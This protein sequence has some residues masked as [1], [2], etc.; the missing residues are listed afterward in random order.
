MKPTTIVEAIERHARERPDAVAITVPGDGGGEDLSLTFA[1]VLERSRR[2][3][4]DI[5]R[6]APE[7]KRVMVLQAPGIDFALS[8]CACFIAGV[9][10]VPTP[11][12]AARANSNSAQRFARLFSDAVPDAIVTSSGLVSRAR[13]LIETQIGM[14]PQIWVMSDGDAHPDATEPSCSAVTPHDLALIQ[15]TSGSTAAPKGVV[16]DHANLAANLAAIQAWF[17]VTPDSVVVNWLP[18]YHDMGLIGGIIEA[19]WCGYRVVLM[20]P[21]TFI[22]RPIAWLEAIDRYRADVSGGANFAYDLCTDALGHAEGPSLDLSRWRLAFSG[23]EPVRATTIDRFTEAFAP[24]GFNKAAFYPCYGLAEATLMA[25]GPA[26]GAVRPVVTHFDAEA[27]ARGL[28]VPASG[29]DGGT[30]RALVSCGTPCQGLALD[31]TDPDSGQPLPH[32]REGEVRLSGPSVMRGYWRDTATR[33]REPL[34]TGDLGFIWEGAL[35][36]TGR[37]KD[38][39]IIRGRNVAPGDVENALAQCHPALAP[40][41]AAAFPVE[42]GDGE[43]LVVAV[44]IRRDHRRNTDWPRVFAAMQGRFADQMGLTATDIVL[45][46]PGALA[47]TTSGKIRRRT[48]RQ[49]YIDGAWKPLARL[50]GALE[51]AGRAGPAK[52]RRMANADRIERMAALVDYLIWRLAQLTAQPEAFLG[53]DTPV[54]GIG[55][56]SLKQVEFL[57]LVESDLG[58]ALPMDWSASAT[59][60][61]SLADLIQSHRD[62]A[63]ATTGDEHGAD[64]AVPGSMVPLSPRQA[65]FFAGTPANPDLFVEVLYLRTP[66][67]LDVDALHRALAALAAAHDAF[68]LRFF[69]DKGGWRARVSDNGGG[70]HF[71][72]IDIADLKKSELAAVRQD[73]LRRVLAAVSVREGPLVS[74]VLLDRGAGAQGVLAVGFHH[75]AVDAVS[76]SVWATQLQDAYRNEA[77]GR[78]AGSAV[79]SDG[80]IPWLFKL[81]EY[82]TSD[83]LA[84]ELDYWRSACGV[85]DDGAFQDWPDG[86][87][88]WRSIGKTTLSAA[89]NGRLLEIYR[90]PVARNA[91]ILAALAATWADATGDRA[92]LIMT[93]GHGRHPFPGTQPMTAVGW[94]ATRYPVGVSVHEGT[95]AGT[96]VQDVI[97]RLSTVPNLGIGYD[98]LRRRPAGDPLREDMERLRRPG[99]FLQ[100]RGNIDETF[101]PDAVMP[102]VGVYHEGRA[103]NQ[104]LCSQ[105]D[106]QPLSVTAGLSDGILYWSVFF[107]PPVSEDRAQEIS[108]GIRRFLIDLASG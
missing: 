48:C 54:D 68:A 92:P 87:L 107:T 84:A 95:D 47:R 60:L 66:K 4:A 45:L 79:R 108:D 101:R 83:E 58:V 14:S 31:I 24:F 55:L 22:A 16:I 85:E 40:A 30:T 56:D 10:A 7:A 90:T 104:S 44:E 37:L 36:V 42:T 71:E 1:D 38:L 78:P 99:I 17:E 61:S 98:L 59:T 94:F 82:G 33:G 12:P 97:T 2:I 50:A 6:T 72:R 5:R 76:L 18:P 29:I 13:W 9:A 62:G 63:A 64:A 52:V 27:A 70:L 51:G 96:L 74:A 26:P 91:V 65:A 49:A 23:A 15:Y 73:A 88:A 19:L 34:A 32:G 103:L 28:A 43:A 35:Y 81:N 93:E 89:D 77:A 8:L 53:P 41:A 102:I 105:G 75:L 57:M 86:A 20:D 69:Q 11:P 46:P 67:G 106:I 25:A 21:K 3:A 100:Y 39:I 80:F